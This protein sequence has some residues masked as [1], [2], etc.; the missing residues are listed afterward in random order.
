MNRWNYIFNFP[1]AFTSLLY[2]SCQLPKV[3]DEII[4]FKLL[5]LIKSHIIQFNSSKLEHCFNFFPKHIG[6]TKIYVLGNSF[7]KLQKYILEHMRVYFYKLRSLDYI[8]LHC[9]VLHKDLRMTSIKV[10]IQV[11][12]ITLRH[13]TIRLY[14]V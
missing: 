5:L 9:V 8:M 7:A 14:R 13:D 4:A 3:D 6:L 10:G 1:I 12:N 11:D 2:P